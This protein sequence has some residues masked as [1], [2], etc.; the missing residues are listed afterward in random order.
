MSMRR[1]GPSGGTD[2]YAVRL[3]DGSWLAEETPRLEMAQLALTP[4]GRAVL[5]GT[6]L[7]QSQR[8]P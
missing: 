7:A 5:A 6:Q 4:K 2:V 8:G 3:A 1:P